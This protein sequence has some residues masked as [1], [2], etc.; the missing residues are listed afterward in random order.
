MIWGVQ[1]DGL[2]VV[3]VLVGGLFVVLGS[4]MG[5]IRPNWFVGIRTPW[6]LSSK[7]SWTKTHRLG[8]RLFVLMGITLLAS[9]FVGSAWG[10]LFALAVVAGCLLWMVL[11]SYLVWRADPEKVPPFGTLPTHRE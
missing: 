9:E 1:L 10:L 11:F 4:V 5:K 3:P 8:G 6:T 2:T 7:L